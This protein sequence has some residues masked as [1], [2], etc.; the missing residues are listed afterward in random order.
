MGESVKATYV[1]CRDA[2][3][4][5]IMTIMVAVAEDL[6][7]KWSEYDADAFVNAWDVANYVADYMTKRV[8][9]DGCDCSIPIVEPSDNE[10]ATI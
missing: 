4:T 1:K 3:E 7:A 9:I 2:G 5:E 6:T 10:S 8:G